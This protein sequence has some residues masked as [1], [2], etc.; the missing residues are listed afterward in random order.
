MDEP[1]RLDRVL[2]ARQ[3]RVYY[4]PFVRLDRFEVAGYQALLRWAHSERGILSAS[5]FLDRATPASLD[6]VGWWVLEVACRQARRWA[7]ESVARDLAPTVSVNLFPSQVRAPDRTARV[8]RIATAADINVSVDERHAL[9]ARHHGTACRARVQGGLVAGARARQ[10]GAPVCA[11]HIETE[12]QL[13]HARDAGC[14]FGQ[15]FYFARPQP[16]DVTSALVHHPFR[17]SPHDVA[18]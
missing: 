5:E 2:T 8:A 17:W 3:L 9:R 4:Q 18:I 11:T 15:G 10:D 13:L 1:I 6:H 14:A 7:D 12:R 16:A